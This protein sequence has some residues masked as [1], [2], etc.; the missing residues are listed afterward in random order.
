MAMAAVIA[1]AH[2][3]KR[4]VETCSITA[5]Y[6]ADTVNVTTFAGLKTLYDPASIGENILTEFVPHLGK[7]QVSATFNSLET[8]PL[9]DF[10]LVITSASNSSVTIMAYG[11][12][13]SI[14][15]VTTTGFDGKVTVTDTDGDFSVVEGKVSYS[16]HY[17]E[18]GGSIVFSVKGV[19]N[20]T[21]YNGAGLF[22]GTPIVTIDHFAHR[23]R[24]H[25]PNEPLMNSG[26]S[27][28]R[29]T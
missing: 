22:K 1:A 20:I 12:P 8:F 18:S 14:Y 9:S 23:R 4:R 13:N 21:I 26:G 17:G 5:R 3:H 25:S 6:G 19:V 11:T 10:Q 16:V 27:C 15:T 7:V 2:G 24:H 28:V 29:M